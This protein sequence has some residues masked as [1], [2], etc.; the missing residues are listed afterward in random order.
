MNGIN[1][2]LYIPLYGKASVS[3]KG[4]ILNDTKA[5][6]IWKK[7]GFELRGKSKSKWLTYYMAMRAKVFDDWTKTQ[8]Q[9][10]SNAIV[11]HIGC[12]MDSRI[13]R[14]GNIKN[15]WYDIDFPQ[16]IEERKKYYSESDSYKMFC[17]DASKTE[18]LSELPKAENAIVIMEG[19]SMYLS[20]KQ[21]SQLFIALQK[22]YKKINLLADFY[23]I[24]GAKA[25]KYK[26][27]INDVGVTS[28]S[29]LDEP[30][31]LEENNGIRF[32]NEK[33]MAPPDL[34]NQ[35]KGTE[36]MF[37]KVMFGGKF[38]R[39][40]YRLYEYEIINKKLTKGGSYE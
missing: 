18:W 1:K 24:F 35:L 28:V 11:L 10:Y 22:Q 19:I 30:K 8:L 3:K 34:I 29:G 40:T 27:P 31:L 16:V 2:T 5:E 21:L 26:N 32:I 36:R 39:K 12:G 38:A 7:E 4:I 9:T 13:E 14:I 15:L 33:T 23:T 20:T 6:E 17:A 25:S 37:F